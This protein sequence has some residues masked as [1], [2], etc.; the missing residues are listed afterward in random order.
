MSRPPANRQTNVPRSTGPHLIIISM[1]AGCTGTTGTEP[2]QGSNEDFD[3]DQ[4]MERR[5]E[6]RQGAYKQLPEPV[7]EETQP[8]ILNEVPESLVQSIKED[9]AGKLDVSDD[10]IEVVSATAVNW[11]DGSLG[12]A[13][14]DQV[15]TQAIVPGYRVILKVGAKHYDYRAAE[16][17]Y[18]F[19][20]ELPTL[21]Q[22]STEM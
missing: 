15:Y 14:P 12:C 4:E 11:N 17:G 5:L 6:A 1:L 18:F 13:R 8:H 22:P 20:C 7:P 2:A 10:T 16:S 9:L 3:R 19:L 21:M